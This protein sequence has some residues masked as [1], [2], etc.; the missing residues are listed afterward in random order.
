MGA[1]TGVAAFEIL[2]EPSESESGSEENHGSIA[3]CGF[4]L[5]RRRASSCES[6]SLSEQ[7]IGKPLVL[8]PSILSTRL[9]GLR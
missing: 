6:C 3:E 2:Y 5:V 8:H 4:A 9:T 7:W 1:S